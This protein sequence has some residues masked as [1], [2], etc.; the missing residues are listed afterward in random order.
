LPVTLHDTLWQKAMLM[1]T[2]MHCS[3]A[4]VAP[5]HGYHAAEP[6]KL[7]SAVWIQHCIVPWYLSASRHLKVDVSTHVLL[8]LLLLLLLLAVPAPHSGSRPLGRTSAGMAATYAGMDGPHNPARRMSIGDGRGSPVAAMAGDM[9]MGMYG[10]GG[11]SPRA[12]AMPGMGM[13]GMGLASQRSSLDS[14]VSPMAAAGALSPMAGSMGAGFA[15]M[16]GMVGGG[17]AASPIPAAAPAAGFAPLASAGSFTAAP[18]VAVAPLKTMAALPLSPS[19]LESMAAG[20]IPAA[21]APG[22][23]T[24]DLVRALAEEVIRLRKA[25]EEKRAREAAGAAK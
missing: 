14:R 8:L 16:G 9:G 13:P 6:L 12:M 5:T 4:L 3:P 22:G 25:V 7:Q 24:A 15:P 11:L 10:S 18:A 23:N 20:V 1:S 17:M 2:I 19:G 21:A